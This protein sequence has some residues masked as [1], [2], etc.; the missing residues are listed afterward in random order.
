MTIFDDKHFLRRGGC[1]HKVS[2]L[3]RHGVFLGCLLNCLGMLHF[4]CRYLTSPQTLHIP[5]YDRL[6]ASFG[7]ESSWNTRMSAIKCPWRFFSATPLVYKRGPF[8]QL[9][10]KCFHREFDIAIP[11]PV[12]SSELDSRVL[13]EEKTLD[14]S[15]I[16]SRSCWLCEGQWQNLN[17]K[18]SSVL[19]HWAP[20][21]Q[22]RYQQEPQKHH[23]DVTDSSGAS[24]FVSRSQQGAEKLIS[25]PNSHERKTKFHH[26]VDHLWMR[27]IFQE[28]PL[29]R[30]RGK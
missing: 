13:L 24:R 28:R 27:M 23:P 17:T 2:H 25:A 1:C 18:S 10:P 8:W 29:E 14:C 21:V 30:G 26:N 16:H 11:F 19:V 12:L 4:S 22:Q 6:S 9:L 5:W 20:V 3:I 7:V 15:V